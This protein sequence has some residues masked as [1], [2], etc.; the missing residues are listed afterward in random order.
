MYSM[1]GGVLGGVA[2]ATPGGD[3]VGSFQMRTDGGAPFDARVARVL[4]RAP[5]GAADG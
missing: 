2:L 4:L 5:R 3:M 1:A